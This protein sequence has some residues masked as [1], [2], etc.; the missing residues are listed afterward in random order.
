[1]RAPHVALSLFFAGAAIIG[2]AQSIK[3]VPPDNRF[4]ADILL[5]VA[6]P[7]DE[8]A[9]TGYLAKAIFDEHKR[10]AVVFGT[11]G[12]GGGD[13]AGKEQAAALGAKR[14]IEARQ[15]LAS[16]GVSDVWFLGGPDTP[17]QDVLRS[18][19]TWNHGAALAQT[20]RLIRLTRPAA[21]LTWLPD[22][23]AGENHG[24]HQAAGVIATE[25]FD[26]AGDPTAFGE[27]LAAP[28]DRNNIGNLTEGL[29]PWQP[30]KLYYFTDATD[31]SFQTGKGPRYSTEELSPAK[32]EFYYK[33]AANEMSFHLT[34]DDTGQM[35]VR[36]I[37]SGDFSYFKQPVLLVLGKSLVG[38][39]VTGDVFESLS[40]SPLAFS[41]ARGY[42]Q[43]SDAPLSIELGGPWSFY[44]KFWAAHDLKL[45]P[46]LLPDF[47][48]ELSAGER[49]QIPLLLHNDTAS[50][51]TFQ[52]NAEL[53]GG[54][55]DL[56]GTGAYEVPA[57]GSIPL[58]VRAKVAPNASKERQ[59][60]TIR[61]SAEGNG[62][63]PL[64]LHVTAT[65]GSL[66]Q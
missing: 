34:Q 30:Q 6:H 40:P 5:V 53:P 37:K 43:S 33:L 55:T 51:A 13:A 63:P 27:Q 8:T 32:N 58:Y 60:L 38:G 35:A 59:S 42:R 24:D 9:V 1:M 22:Y 65:K 2:S 57:H 10:V 64:E 31:T 66:P 61:A 50:E 3:P 47:G 39:H 14:E 21:I 45:L 36:A 7:D 48:V 15:A 52:V 46:D 19:E 29:E 54:W 18:L 20:V 11:R 23:V 44:R 4:K 49:I 56:T 26:L 25:A 12:D 41:A 17:G 28:R 16:F 62:L